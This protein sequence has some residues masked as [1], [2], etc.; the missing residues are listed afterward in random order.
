MGI[1]RFHSRGALVVNEAMR[2]I[3]VTLYDVENSAYVIWLMWRKVE[4]WFSQQVVVTFGGAMVS[5]NL[6]QHPS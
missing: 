6:I 4:R 1:I 2:E 5:P 3:L